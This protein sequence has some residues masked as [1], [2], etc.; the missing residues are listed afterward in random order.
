MITLVPLGIE[1]SPCNAQQLLVSSYQLFDKQKCV[2]NKEQDNV[3]QSSYN[4][5]SGNHVQIGWEIC[6]DNSLG[7]EFR[8]ESWI[9]RHTSHEGP[10]YRWRRHCFPWPNRLALNEVLALWLRNPLI[11]LVSTWWSGVISLR[12]KPSKHRVNT[13]VI[14]GNWTSV[15]SVGNV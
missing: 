9:P 1:L 4:G 13:D 3:L 12:Q 11:R 14:H 8:D 15:T 5:I 2:L 10:N 7:M 6:G